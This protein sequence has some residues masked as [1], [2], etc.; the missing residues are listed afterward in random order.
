MT[1]APDVVSIA[2]WNADLT[3]HAERAPLRGETLQGH[4]FSVG[5]GGKGSNAS[6]A[7][8]RQGARV[9]MVARTGQDDFGRMGL[10]LW[11]REGIDTR[12]VVQDEREASGVALILVYPDGDN[13]IVVSPG[14]NAGLDAA[15]V[16]T[17]TSALTLCKVVMATFEVPLPATREAFALA[18]AA[19]ATTVLTP[20]P[21][22]ACPAELAGLVDLLTPNETELA[23]LAGVHGNPAGA[24]QALLDQGVRAVLVTLGSHGVA[25][26]RP[27]QLVHMEPGHHM[28]VR[29]T[30]GAGDTFNGALAAALARGETLEEAVRWANAAAAL[31]VR[32]S[33]A[34]AGMPSHAE[35]AAFL[36]ESRS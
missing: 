36:Q 27:G 20:A 1:A 15:Q 31:S 6:V 14:A 7:G 9:A 19:G 35:V 21:A 22:R 3:S 18:R 23:T 26:Y 30:I 34:I 11:Q 13:S 5:P 32:A 33:G 16:R 29:D 25:L 28:P 24:A 4:G 2:S 10:D 17:A 12:A 8:A